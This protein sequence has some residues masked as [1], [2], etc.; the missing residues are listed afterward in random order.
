MQIELSKARILADC[1][2][3]MAADAEDKGKD[4]FGIHLSLKDARMIARSLS[5][6]V[7]AVPV[8]RCKD[9][10]Y[11]KPDE[12]E[13]GCDFAGGLPYVKAGDFCSYGERNEDENGR[14]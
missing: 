3:G 10:K 1:I 8:V 13:C 14:T 6:T 11:Y 9:C 4:S 2:E 12:Y 7:D 5:P